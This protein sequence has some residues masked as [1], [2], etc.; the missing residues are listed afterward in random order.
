L[1]EMRRATVATAFLS[2]LAFQPQLENR[3][4]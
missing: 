4:P 3:E 2:I 1:R